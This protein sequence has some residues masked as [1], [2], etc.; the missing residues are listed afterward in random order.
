VKSD[1]KQTESVFAS[2]AHLTPTTTPTR[3]ASKRASAGVLALGGAWSVATPSN[4][5]EFLKAFA[6]KSLVETQVMAGVMTLGM[7]KSQKMSSFRCSL[8]KKQQQQQLDA[9]DNP[10]LSS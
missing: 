6:T 9:M 3:L 8:C 5:G 2:R 1:K 4:C 10:Q 7:V